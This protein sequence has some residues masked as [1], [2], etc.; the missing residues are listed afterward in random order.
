MMIDWLTCEFRFPHNPIKSGRVVSISPDGEIEWESEKR[1]RVR[2]SYE[3]SIQL[4]SSGACG[5]GLAEFIQIDGNYTKFLNGHNVVG[6]N[7]VCLLAHLV[8]KKVFEELGFFYT[9]DLLNSVTSGEFK[10]TRIDV[11]SYIEFKNLDD[12]KAW[13]M[14]CESVA[15]NRQGK[16]VR[17]GTT[18]YFGQ[19]S[20]R[21]MT[22]IYSKYLEL[23]EAKK[24]HKLPLGLPHKSQL[25]DYS[26]NKLRV[27]HTFRSLFLK[28][29]GLNIAKELTPTKI[30]ELYAKRLGKIDMNAQVKLQ[31]YQTLDLPRS[32]RGTY[33]LWQE[34]ARLRDVLSRSVFYSHRT[35]LKEHFIDISL[36]PRDLKTNVVPLLRKIEAKPAK[37]PQWSES[38]GLIY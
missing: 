3:S 5:E 23:T 38:V 17:K 25:L 11:T 26:K 10:V 29:L 4:R 18:V 15:R 30:G 34:G 13:L 32:V 9:R 16:A 2:G 19:Y 1:M 31:S 6:S 7:D 22:K 35:I 36:P 37:M 8:I 33:M 24:G 20:R 14:A 27:E 28:D 21:V 12:A